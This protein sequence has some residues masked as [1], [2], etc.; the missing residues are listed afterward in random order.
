MATVGDFGVVR[1]QLNVCGVCSG[2]RS[3]SQKETKPITVTLV[4]CMNIIVE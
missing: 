3:S 4:D 2:E 1:D